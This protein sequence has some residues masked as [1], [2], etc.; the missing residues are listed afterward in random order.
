MRRPVLRYL[1]V[2]WLARLDARAKQWRLVPFRSLYIFVKWSLVGLGAY[3]LIGHFV[4]TW[5]WAAGLW[6]LLAPLAYGLYLGFTGR[7]RTPE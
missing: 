7:P 2:A 3:V 5:G 4:I 1:P 6:F